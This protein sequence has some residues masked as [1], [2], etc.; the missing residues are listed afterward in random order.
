MCELQM[1]ARVRVLQ[2]AVGVVN[3]AIFTLALTSIYPF[4]SGEFSVDLPSPNDVEWYYQDGLVTVTAPYSIDN[5]GFYDVVDLR[6]DYSVTNSTSAELA[7]DVISIGTIPAGTVRSDE[8]EFGFDI[9]DLYER[10]FTSMVFNDDL[11]YMS[12]GVSCYYTMELIHFSAEY[13]VTLQ[14]DALIQEF[15]VD[16]FQVSGTELL[17]DYHL[18]TSPMLSGLAHVHA[19]LLD[20]GVVV[21]EDDQTLELGTTSEGTLAFAVPLGSTPDSVLLEV[22]V[23]DFETQTEI[24]IPSEVPL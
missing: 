2:I 17:V 3:F 24:P 14:W 11:I 15:E 9:L 6:L 19:S 1:V 12:I 21:S 13:E 5:G 20:D 18:T 10:G 7:S 8:I 22:T 23:M 16:G 4:P